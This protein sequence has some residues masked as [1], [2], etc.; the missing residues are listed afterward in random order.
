M[1]EIDGYGAGPALGHGSAGAIVSAHDTVTG[2]DVAIRYLARE[3]ST[4]PGFMAGFRTDMARLA[5]IEQANVALVYE[6][7]DKDNQAALVTE[8]I[9]GP[10]LG[11]LLRPGGPLPPDAAGYAM[12]RILTGLGAVHDRGILHGAVRP[13][14]VLVDP[15]GVV[16]VVDVGLAVP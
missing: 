10:S 2:A 1:W 16:K 12:A 13:E 3:L 4:S 8:L 11:A 6:L 9:D 7:I 15:N 5:V 14:S